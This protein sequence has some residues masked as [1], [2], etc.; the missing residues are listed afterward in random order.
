MG[1]DFS[2]RV[3][4]FKLST[5]PKDESDL[6]NTMAIYLNEN[7]LADDRPLESRD[8]ERCHFVGRAKTGR[9]KQIIVKFCHYQDRK[10]VYARK[11]NLKGNPDKVFITEDL[12]A[13]NHAV[14]KQ[15]LPLKKNSAIDSF[16][17]SNGQI[18]VK[19]NSVCDPVKVSVTDNI[20][21]KFGIASEDPAP[22]DHATSVTTST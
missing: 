7:V 12:T 15:L 17:T 4:N 14:V 6:I 21:T 22:R 19:K 16:W 8:I 10:R 2:L 3:N 1:E 20:P 11:T 13:S 18:Y 9:P 5:P